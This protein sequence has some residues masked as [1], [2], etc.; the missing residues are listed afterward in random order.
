MDQILT[1]PLRDA[2]TACR[3]AGTWPQMTGRP[4]LIERDSERIFVPVNPA[5]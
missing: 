4:Q 5:S 1:L 2:C 3:N